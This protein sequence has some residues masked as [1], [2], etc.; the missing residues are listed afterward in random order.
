M[1]I[2]FSSNTRISDLY[3]RCERSRKHSRRAPGRQVLKNAKNIIIHPATS[4]KPLVD[5]DD[6]PDEFLCPISQEIM[7]DPVICSD[8]SSYERK[9]IEKWFE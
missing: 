2:L 3:R 9:V 1:F 6:V 4:F 5:F 8:G 7:Q